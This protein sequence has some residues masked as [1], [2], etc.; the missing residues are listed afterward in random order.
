LDLEPLTESHDTEGFDCGV[1]ALDHYLRR[2]AIRDQQADKAQTMVAVSKGRVVAYFTL[3]A[4]SIEPDVATPRA[5]KGQ[6]T[7][8]IP[9]ILLARLAVDRSARGQGLGRAML[10][11]ALARSAQAADAIGA[12]VVLVHAKDGAVRGFYEHFGFEQSPT[13]DLQLMLLMKDIRKTLGGG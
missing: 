1:G 10:L 12:R 13:G 7:Q 11:Q 2:Q 4:A 3:A 5:A 8:A 6:G 9:A